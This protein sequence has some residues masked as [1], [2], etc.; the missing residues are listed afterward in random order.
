MKKNQKFE[1]IDEALAM[2]C[3]QYEKDGLDLESFLEK[4]DGLKSLNA[5]RDWLDPDSLIKLESPELRAEIIERAQNLILDRLTQSD[6][7]LTEE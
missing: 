7:H 3:R 1:T 4:E 2:L 5:L 6:S